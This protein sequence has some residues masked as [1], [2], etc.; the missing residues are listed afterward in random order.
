MLV[1]YFAAVAQTFD[2]ACK[3]HKHGRSQ[4]GTST[5]SRSALPSPKNQEKM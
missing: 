1:F 4:G 2:V 5:T 3:H